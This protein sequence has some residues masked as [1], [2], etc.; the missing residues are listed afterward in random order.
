MTDDLKNKKVLVIG[1]GRAGVAAARY[2]AIRG[3]NVTVSEKREEKDVTEFVSKLSGLPIEYSFGRNDVRLMKD[4]QLIVVSP[5]VPLSIEG[6]G[7]AR[8]LKIPVINELE[9]AVREIKTPMIAVTGTNG[10]TTTTTL[11]GHLL[12]ECGIKNCVGGNIGTA[13][14]D[15]INDAKNVDWV[16]VEVS[17]FQLETTPSLAP[18]IGVLLNVTPDHLDRH[19]SF[20]EYLMLKARLF[21]TLDAECFGIYNA[22]DKVVAD[23]VEKSHAQLVP[24]NSNGKLDDGGWFEKD[25]LWM[26]LPGKAAEQY[27]LG[28][29]DLK[30][31][32]NRE[33]M[34]ASIMTA[35]LCG[36]EKNK[37]QKGLETFKGLPHRIELVGEYRNVQYYDDSKGTNVGATVAAL[38]NFS[39]P[40]I[41]IA[42]GLDKGA[43]YEPMAPFIRDRV[44]R[45]ILIGE[46]KDKMRSELGDLTETVSA[47]TMEDAV[48]KASEAAAAGDVVLL[49]PACAS[50]DMFRDYAHRG[51][52]FAQAV[53]KLKDG[54]H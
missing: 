35:A 32:H 29:V 50:Y 37:I 11:I 41:L 3:A 30:G 33:N 38:E 22:A 24:F 45:L 47:E 15:L 46:A 39:A 5:G 48:L 19:A 7:E 54:I 43:S 44:K 8:N 34:L 1:L 21:G 49:S 31:A 20:E 51:E 4:A 6:L 26:K 12:T 53:R 23:A 10:K 52:V 28:N 42:G 13:L 36:G 18:K 25:S 14:T 9:L 27:N 40:V 16:V 2:A 17:S